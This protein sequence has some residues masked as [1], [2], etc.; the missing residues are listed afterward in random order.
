M[1]DLSAQEIIDLLGLIPHRIEGGLYRETYR[2]AEIMPC[3]A[4]SSP[5]AGRKNLSTAIYYML[6]P[7]TFSAIHRLPAD[8]IFHFYI[9]DPVQM[10]QLRPDG[11]SA[12]VTLGSDIT[13]SQ[14]VQVI[15]PKGTWQGMILN[16]GGSFALMGTTMSPGFDFSEYEAGRQ[17]ELIER[18][19]DSETLIR[20]MTRT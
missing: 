12:T 14:H 20:K 15:V 9:G 17:E 10:L 7:D 16:E 3:G 5:N 2:S 8:E 4:E 13:N 1:N 19:P 11:T 6:T 18:Y